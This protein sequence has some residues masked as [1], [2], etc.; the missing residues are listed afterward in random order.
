MTWFVDILKIFR[1][2]ASDKTF[3]MLKVP[4]MMDIK[5]ILL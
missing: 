3:N 2:I 4:S 1:R 5:E